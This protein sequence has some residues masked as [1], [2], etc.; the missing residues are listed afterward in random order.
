[1]RCIGFQLC[2]RFIITAA[3]DENKTTSSAIGV[4]F[5]A[6]PQPLFSVLPLSVA[7][8]SVLK[9]VPDFDALYEDE[10]YECVYYYLASDSTADKIEDV[11]SV[12]LSDLLSLSEGVSFSDSDEVSLGVYT[13]F[14]FTFS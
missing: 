12:S 4:A 7:L 11:L 10:F 9:T 8:G 5:A 13:A 2:L 1:M 14:T 3:R 6:E